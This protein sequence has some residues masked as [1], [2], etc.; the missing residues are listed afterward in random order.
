MTAPL[1]GPSIVQDYVNP[2]GP[3]VQF[4]ELPTDEEIRVSGKPY[5]MN[6]LRVSREELNEGLAHAAERIVI[7]AKMVEHDKKLKQYAAIKQKI[8]DMKEQRRAAAAAEQPEPSKVAEAIE[9]MDPFGMA[10]MNK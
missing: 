3:V 2:M 10:Q 8:S 9:K 5:V 6:I 1:R 7:R 4:G